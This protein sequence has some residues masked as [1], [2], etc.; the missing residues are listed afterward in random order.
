M[1]EL[2]RILTVAGPASS[3]HCGVDLK[4]RGIPTS[5]GTGSEAEELAVTSGATPWVSNSTLTER[6]AYTR[7]GQLSGDDTGRRC[8]GLRISEEALSVMG[9]AQA[10]DPRFPGG[11]TEELLQQVESQLEEIAGVLRQDGRSA[12]EYSE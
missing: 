4:F 2:G 3:Q 12:E 8:R 1:A 7:P 6:I 5:Q 11:N 10:L 9:G